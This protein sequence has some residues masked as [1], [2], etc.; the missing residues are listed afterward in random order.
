MLLALSATSA[1]ARPLPQK[2][3][4]TSTAS[5]IRPQAD[6][7]RQWP[8]GTAGSAAAAIDDAVQQPTAVPGTDFIYARNANRIT[9]VSLANLAL[10]DRVPGSVTAWF[11]ANTGATTRLKVDL[12][13][14]EQVLNTTTL[15]G[16]SGFAWRS[17]STTQGLDQAVINALSLRFTSLDGGDTNLRAAYASVASAPCDSTHPALGGYGGFGGTRWPAACWNPFTAQSPFNRAL[18]ANARLHPRS[19]QIVQRMR[20]DLPKNKQVANFVAHNDGSSGEPTYYARSS[21]PLYTIHCTANTDDPNGFGSSPCPMEGEKIR[22]PAQAVPEGGRAADSS[23]PLYERADAHI[24]VVDQSTGKLT[25]FWQVQTVPLPAGGGR[26]NVAWAGDSPVDGTGLST[27]G[28]AT[29]ANYSSLAGRIRAEELQ[30]GKIDH[31]LLIGVRCDS[32]QYVF[33]ANHSGLPCTKSK[34]ALA[35]ADAPAM[36]SLLRLNMTTAQIDALPAAVPTWKRT[37][38]KAMSQYGMYIG[39][40]GSS[41]YFNVETES[42]NQYTSRGAPDAWLSFAASNNWPQ[43]AANADYPYAHRLGSMRANADGIDWD[44]MVWSKLVVLDPCV[45]QGN[46]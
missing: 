40:T 12:V 45:T 10:D 41:F 16:G 9:E 14:G 5:I 32:G 19:A 37:I 20:T 29:A 4:A 8:G 26:I 44:A 17:L 13:R 33:P 38:L 23:K 2:A 42:G 6:I 36:G 15:T 24:T 3:A 28:S 46:C 27:R 31:A 35:T 43:V 11:Y 34:P 21:D 30:A 25:S 22:I 7:Q 18:P 39:E 1:P